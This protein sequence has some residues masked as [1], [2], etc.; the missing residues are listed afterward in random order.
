GNIAIF[1]WVSSSSASLTATA[2]DPDSGRGLGKLAVMQ[3]EDLAAK[4]DVGHR[5]GHSFVGL[6]A[7]EADVARTKRIE[8]RLS[9]R[10][11]IVFEDALSVE[12]LG[13]HD[14]KG[15]S[16]L[17]LLHRGMTRVRPEL[18]ELV[19]ERVDV[20]GLSALGPFHLENSARCGGGIIATGWIANLAQRRI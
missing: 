17:D 19:A 8:F 13:P 9:L 20:Q 1:G 5:T 18:G 3:L 12:R 4:G 6:L 7:P 15:H 11:T 10:G 2:R 14:L 16:R